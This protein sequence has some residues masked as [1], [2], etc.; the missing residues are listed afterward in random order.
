MSKL[1]D[2]CFQANLMRQ[3]AVEV[4]RSFADA[5]EDGNVEVYNS[6]RV[7]RLTPEQSLDIKITA[8]IEEFEL[9]N[10]ESFS[11]ALTW[12]RKK[13]EESKTLEQ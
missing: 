12:T 6:G 1:R 3:D 10:T 4:L 13:D 11:L 8:Q 2:T 5:L 7:I 9:V